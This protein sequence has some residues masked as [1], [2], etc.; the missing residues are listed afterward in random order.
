MSGSA[1]VPNPAGGTAINPSPPPIAP[2]LVTPGDW[3]KGMDA[4]MLGHATLKG[5]D[6]SD[7]AKAFASAAQAHQAAEQYIGVPANDLMRIPKP[8]DSAGWDAV[9]QR[10]GAPKTAA[11]YDLTS[12][13]TAAGAD[14]TPEFQEF[15]RQT[16][17]ALHLPKAQAPALGQAILKF[18]D[19]T[20]MAA[21]TETA[22]ALAVERTALDRNWGTSKAQNMVVA[23]RAASA[24]GVD[25]ETVKA[26]ESQVGYAK[27]MNMFL[28][29]GQKIG[30]DSFIGTPPGG[31]PR[32][33]TRD[34]AIARKAELMSDPIWRDSYLKGDVA[35]NR[36][37]QALLTLIVG[38]DTEF[39]RS[40]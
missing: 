34:T 4:G 40:V 1:A 18:Q 28:Q 25:P 6:M 20:G 27:V 9:W 23:Q 35:K 11:D 39:S 21:A 7:P 13:K 2:P 15:V 16:A 24:L 29:V 38:D 33:L 17:A 8:E 32:V 36:E 22:A 31:G 3:S 19:G 26:L 14:T 10:L 5:W 12:V 37:F 30:E